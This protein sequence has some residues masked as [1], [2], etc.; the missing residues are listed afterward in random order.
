MYQIIHRS[1][2]KTYRKCDD[3]VVLKIKLKRGCP[4]I[5]VKIEKREV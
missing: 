3:L 5:R 1:R 4:K 2:A